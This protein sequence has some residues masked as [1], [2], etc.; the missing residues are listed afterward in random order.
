MSDSISQ[1][2][3]LIFAKMAGLLFSYVEDSVAPSD[4]KKAVYHAR[5]FTKLRITMLDGTVTGIHSPTGKFL[6][7]ADEIW[8]MKPEFSKQWHGFKLTVFPDG[9]SGIEL[10]YDEDDPTFFFS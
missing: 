1:R 5:G 9:K 2:F 8:D 3:D 6:D 10:D 4:W 7:L